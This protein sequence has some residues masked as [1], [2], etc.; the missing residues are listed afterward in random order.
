MD[1]DRNEV[2]EKLQEK[3]IHYAQLYFLRTQFN[4]K[5]ALLMLPYM[6]AKMVWNIVCYLR[7]IAFGK[8]RPVTIAVEEV[9]LQDE[10]T[11]APNT[12]ELEADVADCIVP[13]TASGADK[14]A[15]NK[16]LHHSQ[17]LLVKR[18][19]AGTSLP[20]R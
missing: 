18:V 1:V 2:I 3:G 11:E 10:H 5:T 7:T 14:P 15:H 13:S 16:P 4:R 9:L 6:K 20:T 19:P 17:F 12:E 8:E